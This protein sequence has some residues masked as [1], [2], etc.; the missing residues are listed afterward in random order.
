M[1]NGIK[2]KLDQ[3]IEIGDHAAYIDNNHCI[4]SVVKVV[5]IKKNSYGEIMVY[6]TLAVKEDMN[7]QIYEYVKPHNLILTK[8]K[9]TM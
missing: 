5:D 8:T 4:S 7:N 3:V 6:V 2:D 1:I 9:V